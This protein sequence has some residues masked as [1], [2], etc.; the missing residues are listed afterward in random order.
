MSYTEA[1]ELCSVGGTE[2]NDGTRQS[3]RRSAERHL[4]QGTSS[5]E[6]GML[7]LQNVR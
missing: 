3:G 7:A 6:G 2:E 1:L 4:L 5:Y